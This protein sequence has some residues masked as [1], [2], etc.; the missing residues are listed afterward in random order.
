MKQGPKPVGSKR[1]P[2]HQSTGPSATVDLLHEGL[3][4]SAVHVNL[5]QEMI[6]L[7]EDRLRLDLNELCDSTTYRRGWHAPAGML[8]TQ[9]AAFVTSSFHDTV[10]VSGQ[11]WEALFCALIVVTAF[12][13]LAAFIRG[14]RASSADSLIEKLKAGPPRA[15]RSPSQNCA[16]SP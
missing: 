14:H 1:L 8:I 6:I 11:Q 3:K 7:T 12:W 4:R 13:L 15:G 16:G 9:V 2:R 10:G 5:G